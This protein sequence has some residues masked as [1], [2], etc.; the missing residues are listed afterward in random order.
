[1]GIIKGDFRIEA[2]TH[3][4]STSSKGVCFLEHKLLMPRDGILEHWRKDSGPGNGFTPLQF[5]EPSLSSISTAW[6]PNHISFEGLN[7]WL[8][9]SWLVDS[10]LED[11][12]LEDSWLVDSW[13]GS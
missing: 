6:T 2:D 5:I 10:W 8:T 4:I 12:W 3:M 1:M 7:S 11:N 9:D 13:L